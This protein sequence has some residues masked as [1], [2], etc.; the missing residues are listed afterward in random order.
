MRTYAAYKLQSVCNIE[1]LA[2]L[3]C[4]LLRMLLQGLYK[5]INFGNDKVDGLVVMPNTLN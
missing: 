4:I 1:F 5:G 3:S 2:A